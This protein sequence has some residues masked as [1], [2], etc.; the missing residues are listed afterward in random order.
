MA[1]PTVSPTPSSP[2]AAPAPTPS[3][4][5][6]LCTL[7][8]APLNPSA[9]AGD[10]CLVNGVSIDLDS[11]WHGT[12]ECSDAGG[13]W[14]EY[15]CQEA[16]D[17]YATLPADDEYLPAF[18]EAWEPKCCGTQSPTAAPAPTPS[19]TPAIEEEEEDSLDE[20]DWSDDDDDCACAYEN[21]PVC[22]NNEYQYPNACEATCAGQ[23]M[24]S[25]GYCGDVSGVPPRG[26][27]LLLSLWLA[28]LLQ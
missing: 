17:Y 8:D 13:S 2:T 28:A 18:L 20:D 19:H 9:A 21:A 26:L 22:V 6:L 16:S 25:D 1:S 10:S 4:S 15:S 27:A 14:S 24:W 5:H 7:A 11:N 3:S 23:T 12:T